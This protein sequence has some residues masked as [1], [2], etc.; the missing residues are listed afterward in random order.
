MIFRRRLSLAEE[1]ALE[2]ALDRAF[3]TAREGS[4]VLSPARVRAR[5]A[6]DRPRPPAAG[7]RGVLLLGRVAESS[8]AVGLTAMLFV[9]TLGGL[10]ARTE[11]VQVEESGDFVVRVTAPLDD[12][13]FLRLVR[14]GRAAPLVDDI[15]PAISPAALQLANAETEPALP[16]EL[17]QLLR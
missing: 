14:L 17:S 15:D 11:T 8:L 12:S 13:R 9:A 1:T 10:D 5:V 2:A 16:R 4:T 7:W 6:W 3:A